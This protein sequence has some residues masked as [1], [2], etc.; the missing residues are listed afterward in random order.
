M[1]SDCLISASVC[2]IGST[3]SNDFGS[4]DSRIV[5]FGV[6]LDSSKSIL[7]FSKSLVS[8]VVSGPKGL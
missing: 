6:L 5:D 2:E 7:V 4:S 3:F 8:I 1:V